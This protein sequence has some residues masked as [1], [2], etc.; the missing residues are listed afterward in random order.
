MKSIIIYSE[1]CHIEGGIY[2]GISYKKAVG[3]V[4]EDNILF[5]I[6]LTVSGETYADRKADLI[7]KAIEYSRIW[8]DFCS[9]SYGELSII[10]EFFE[11]NGKKY[12]LL[13]EFRENCIV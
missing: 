7:E 8:H 5:Y 10:Q 13:N 3:E 9:F 6:P 12:G 1:F 4:G 2:E 11:K